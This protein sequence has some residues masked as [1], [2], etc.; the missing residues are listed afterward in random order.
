MKFQA[1]PLTSKKFSR[2]TIIASVVLTLFVALVVSLGVIKV[3]PYAMNILRSKGVVEVPKP[4]ENPYY[5]EGIREFELGKYDEAIDSFN[6][7]IQQNPKLVDAYHYRG[8]A[9]F[10]TQRFQNAIQD[11]NK[12]LQM[13]PQNAE[14]YHHRGQAYSSSGNN[15]QAI[16]DYTQAIS[17][18][19]DFA[20]AYSDRAQ[21]YKAQ[22]K[23]ALALNDLNQALKYD[24]GQAEGYL[25]AGNFTSKIR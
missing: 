17:L 10:Q 12:V 22:G 9:Y 14:A 3:L 24:P 4:S 2:K 19:P 20:Q 25:S 16:A 8:Q 5:A 1:T 23:E 11:Y 7:A 15:D 18:K 13:A 21:A 6:K